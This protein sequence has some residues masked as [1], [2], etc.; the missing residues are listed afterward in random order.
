MNGGNCY[1]STVI[2]I[3]TVSFAVRLQ[4]MVEYL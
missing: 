1:D 4:Q 3:L 2:L